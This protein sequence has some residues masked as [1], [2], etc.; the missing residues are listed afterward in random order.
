MVRALYIHIYL[1]NSWFHFK[2][3]N[4]SKHVICIHLAIQEKISFQNRR[5]YTLCAY[6]FCWIFLEWNRWMNFQSL[7][8]NAV[9]NSFETSC[10]TLCFWMTL[11]DC[12]LPF[13][14]CLCSKSKHFVWKINCNFFEGNICF[15]VSFFFKK[16][17]NSH[18]QFDQWTPGKHTGQNRG[19]KMKS[20]RHQLFSSLLEPW[21]RNKEHE[22]IE[23]QDVQLKNVF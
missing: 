13:I 4:Y 14:V 7:I 23:V 18:T 21:Y 12:H 16:K 22:S 19:E 9:K 8:W 1:Y 2:R 10:G 5:T 11:N 20:N 17:K 15:D 6:T 3:Y